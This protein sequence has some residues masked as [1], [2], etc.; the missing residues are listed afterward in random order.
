MRTRDSIF[1]LFPAF[2]AFLLCSLPTAESHAADQ[3][4]VSLTSA[5]TVDLVIPESLQREADAAIARGLDFLAS[6]QNKDGSWSSRDY[7][8]LTALA[9]WAFVDSKHPERDEILRKA[10]DF[11]L[12]CAREN[13]SIYKDVPDREGSGLNN[14]NTSICM[15]A[16]HA[17]GDERYRKVVLK[18]RDFTT[19]NQHLEGTDR[20]EGG[21]GYDASSPVK[22]AYTD[23]LNTYYTLEGLKLTESAE[24][25]RPPDQKPAKADK[26][27]AVGYIEKL[28]N[29]KGSGEENEGGFIYRPGDSPAGS[30]TNYAGVVTFRSYGSITYAGSLALIFADVPRDDPRVISALDWSA[31]HWTL[32]ENPGMGKAGLYFFYNVMAKCLNATG[33]DFIDQK[34]TGKRINW[35]HSLTTRLVNSQLVLPNG[36]GYWVNKVGRWWE[37]DPNLVTAYTIRSLQMARLDDE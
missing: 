28:Q 30:T 5:G 32:D 19:R 33:V 14:Y 13:G 9:M 24:D 26:K 22:R 10:G 21:W 12:S 4:A 36:R 7:P 31:R 20:Y 3:P 6:T 8:A 17:T 18:A 27:A 25:S 15:A 1:S 37:N 35:R 34:S 16:L 2:L 23:L 29:Q 11:I